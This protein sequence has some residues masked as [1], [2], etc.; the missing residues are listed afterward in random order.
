[1]TTAISELFSHQR[2]EDFIIDHQD[3]LTTSIR[4]LELLQLENA[5]QIHLFLVKLAT[6]LSQES[7]T[8]FR[9]RTR[10]Y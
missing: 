5:H 10:V 7:L 6:L 2:G 9:Q 4:R 8:M 1:M 3:A